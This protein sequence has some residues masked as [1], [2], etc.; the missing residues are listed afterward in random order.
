MRV[1][2]SWVRWSCVAALS[3]AASAQSVW[4]VDASAAPGGDGSSWAQ[5]FTELEEALEQAGSGD[6]IWV[7]D[8]VYRPVPSVSADPRDT[9][10][11]VAPG[12]SLYGGFAGG[13]PSVAQRAGLFTSTVLSGDIGVTG[14]DGDNAHHVIRTYGP[15]V[16]DGFRITD[17]NALGASPPHGGGILCETGPV[18]GIPGLY[19]GSAL[20]LRNSTIARNQASR[21]A[22]L[23]GQLA[24]LR[25]SLCDFEDNVAQGNGGAL[26]LQTSSGRFDL[27]RVRRNTAMGNGGGLH[28]TSIA[29]YANGRPVVQ[30]HTSL[31]HDNRAIADGGAV[32]ISGSALTAGKG[33]F[34]NCTFALNSAGNAGGGLF[35]NTSAQVPAESWIENSIV[36]FNRAPLDNDIA[37]QHSV[38]YSIAPGQSGVG[39]VTSAPKFA[40]PRTRDFRLRA[41]SAAVDA[42][43]SNLLPPDA[44]D[45]DGDGVLFEFLP[46]DLDRSAR[47][48]GAHVDLGCYERP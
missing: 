24:G 5:A 46:Y 35:A 23:F 29:E 21:G 39:L 31:F 33:A 34:T 9:A 15:V 17:G 47:W 30:F 44:L 4:H 22:G 16:I 2:H 3:G 27:C 13:E 36:W 10:F 43:S 20:T 18:P 41:G 19:Q 37:G 14:F 12:L 26:A 1:L 6:E 42:G 48:I 7:A 38:W 32:M 8:G 28:L 40:N 25:V 45:V 11:Y